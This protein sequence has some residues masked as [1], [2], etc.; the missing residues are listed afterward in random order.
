MAFGQEEHNFSFP[1]REEIG[2]SDGF[3]RCETVHY[4]CGPIRFLV[5]GEMLRLTESCRARYGGVLF[6]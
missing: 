4:H 2:V 1:I 5:L 3:A 6:F